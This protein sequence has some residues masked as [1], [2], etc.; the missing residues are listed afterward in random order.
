[1]THRQIIFYVLCIFLALYFIFYV[2][3][4]LIVDL[5]VYITL[6][7]SFEVVT[8]SIKL[9]CFGDNLCDEGV[10]LFGSILF[11]YKLSIK[12]ECKKRIF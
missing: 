9:Y 3:S 7:G 10:C 1:M 4:P 2:G 11:P 5:N 6:S 8:L 12:S